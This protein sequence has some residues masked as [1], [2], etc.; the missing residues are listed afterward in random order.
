[1]DKNNLKLFRGSL[2]RVI[3][4][5]GFF[6]SFYD[7]FLRQSEEISDIFKHRDIDQLKDKLRSTLEMVAQTVDGQ[8][9]LTLYLEM[10]GRTHQRLHVTHRHFDMW[11]TAL[12]DTVSAY[13][14][15]FDEKIGNAWSQVI[16]MVIDRIMGVMTR[17]EKLAS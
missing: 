7:R 1:M 4:K 14:P 2:A 9:G 17:S 10:L 8:P 13:D 15:A 5:D 16:G 6:D 11:K 12:I 3:T